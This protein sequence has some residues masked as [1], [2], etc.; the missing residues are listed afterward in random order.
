MD[1]VFMLFEFM[2]IRII[3]YLYGPYYKLFININVQ[4]KFYVNV[5][6]DEM[7]K[8]SLSAKS[9]GVFRCFIRNSYK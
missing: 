8:F 5:M 2:N 1:K 7:F 9:L 3:I 4:L 6:E